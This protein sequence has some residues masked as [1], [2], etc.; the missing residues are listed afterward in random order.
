MI[1]RVTN[2]TDGN[3]TIEAL[4]TSFEPGESKD[5]S[6]N[7]KI[8]DLMI[9]NNAELASLIADSSITLEEIQEVLKGYRSG[10]VT[11]TPG[12]AVTVT[13]N[14]GVAVERQNIDV[15]TQ[16]STTEAY[17]KATFWGDAVAGTDSGVLVQNITENTL[18]LYLGAD[19]SNMLMPIDTAY[20][21]I[22]VRGE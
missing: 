22:E 18:E 20:V 19:I 17:S 16:D 13:H 15:L 2:L 8:T 3:L 5:V 14:L 11:L 4:R 12:A 7:R 9:D 21:N 10:A 1:L 6:L